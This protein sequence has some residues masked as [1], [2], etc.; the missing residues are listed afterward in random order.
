VDGRRHQREETTKS[1]MRPSLQ[2]KEAR[3]IWGEPYR[4]SKQSTS[5]EEFAQA[6]LQ[7]RH[8]VGKHNLE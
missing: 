1:C 5:N 6:A 4:K 3:G 7:V 2:A 8:F